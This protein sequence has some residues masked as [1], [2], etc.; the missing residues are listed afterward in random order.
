M[1]KLVF[2][3]AVPDDAEAIAMLLHSIADDLSVTLLDHDFPLGVSREVIENLSPKTAII[4]AEKMESPGIVGCLMLE[5]Y[6]GHIHPFDHVS[7]IA[8]YIDR[9]F[10]DKGIDK[11]LLDE[12][13]KAAI[14]AGFEKIYTFLRVDNIRAIRFFVNNGFR[15]V[16]TIHNFAKKD[17]IYIDGI[18]IERFI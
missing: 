8:M 11:Q 14:E 16:G 7:T 15:I 12:G 2:R 5:S 17:N 1:E 3:H 6:S 4:I 13:F 10:Y 9:E 18:I